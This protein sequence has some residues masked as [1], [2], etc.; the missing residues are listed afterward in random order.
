MFEE[1]LSVWWDVNEIYTN[2]WQGACPPRGNLVASKGYNLLVL[3]ASEWQRSD[4]YENVDVITIPLED[5]L[6]ESKILSQHGLICTTAK[7]IA[8]RIESGQKVLITCMAGVNRS[9]LLSA[10]TLH[11]VTGLTGEACIKQVKSRRRGALF[12]KTFQKYICETCK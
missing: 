4:V 9:G 2:L 11:Y 12:N 3:T 6:D 8:L 7:S 10:V 5:D 1:H